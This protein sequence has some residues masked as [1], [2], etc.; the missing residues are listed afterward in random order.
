MFDVVF[1]SDSKAPSVREES[2]LFTMVAIR[3]V[4]VAELMPALA[5]FFPGEYDFTV[6]RPG[7]P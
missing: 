3:D 2:V 6:R 5:K 7:D 4:I 1:A